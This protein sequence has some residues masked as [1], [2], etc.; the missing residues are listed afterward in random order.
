MI[1]HLT[2]HAQ[3]E[4]DEIEAWLRERSPDAAERFRGEIA[5][6]LHRLAVAPR[7]GAVFRSGPT[8]RLLLRGTGHH[9]HYTV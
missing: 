5:R 2:A 8:R 6:A 1:V 3:D 4:A 9:L 7:S